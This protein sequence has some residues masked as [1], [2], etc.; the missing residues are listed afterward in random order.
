MGKSVHADVLD[1]ALV[2]LRSNA[3]KILALSGQPASFAAAM[4]G[5]LAQKTVAPADFTLGAGGGGSSRRLSVAAKS[6]LAVSASG[7]ADHVALV[8]EAA[9]RL[10]FVTDCAPVALLAGGTLDLS[11]WTIDLGAVV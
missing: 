2:L 3:S 8:D 6:G 10:L 1:A 9:G 4:S 5:A 11:G 7:S